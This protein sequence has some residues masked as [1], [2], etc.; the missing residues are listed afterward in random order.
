MKRG[1]HSMS[2]AKWRTGRTSGGKGAK[3]TLGSTPR[4]REGP[5]KGPRR[6]RHERCALILLP[7]RTSLQRLRPAARRAFG[8][9][10]GDGLA[11]YGRG[12]RIAGAHPRLDAVRAAIV[13]EWNRQRI[14]VDAVKRG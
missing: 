14:D 12:D 4:A 3:G 11:D 1:S 10:R 13:D 2:V 7:A 5:A 6:A 9:R 8:G